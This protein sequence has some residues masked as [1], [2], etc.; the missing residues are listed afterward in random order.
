MSMADIDIVLS[1]DMIV[2]IVSM[3]KIDTLDRIFQNSTLHREKMYIDLIFDGLA[4]IDMDKS[5]EMQVREYHTN[6]RD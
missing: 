3:M 1:P 6:E 2:H 5:N 4:S